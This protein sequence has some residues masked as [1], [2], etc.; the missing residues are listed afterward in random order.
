VYVSKEHLVITT[1]FDQNLYAFESLSDK[2]ILKYSNPKKC[3]FTSVVWYE[4]MIV[5][6]DEE[7]TLHCIQVNSDKAIE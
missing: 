1:S 7:G 2:L 5:A 4:G 6:A 3:V